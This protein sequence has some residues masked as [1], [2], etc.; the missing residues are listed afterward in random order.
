MFLLCFEF[1]LVLL[2]PIQFRNELNRNSQV[3]LL[4][5][6]NQNCSILCVGRKPKSAKK[7]EARLHGIPIVKESFLV[8][9][10]SS[11]GK[12][13]DITKHLVKETLKK[14][15]R[16]SLIRRPRV[17]SSTISRISRSDPLG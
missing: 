11:E 16:N 5:V 7:D 8:D 13:P 4:N 3:F 6:T 10:F 2:F 14:R 17:H 12:L 15:M 9:L 1:Y